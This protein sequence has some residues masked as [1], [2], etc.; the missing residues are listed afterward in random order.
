MPNRPATPPLIATLRAEHVHLAQISTLMTEQLDAIDSGTAVDSHILY[1]IMSYMVSWADRY[2]HPRE[3]LIYGRAAELDAQLADDVDSLQRQH[4]A[5]ASN[6]LAL[7]KLIGRWRAGKAT[8]AAVVRAGRDYV[9]NSDR[10]MQSEEQLVFPR[11]EAVLGP[12]DWQEL[13]LDD[14]LQAAGDPVFGP[15]IDREFRNLARKLRRSARRTIERGVMAE[16][17][18]LESALESLEILG[19]ANRMALQTTGDTLRCA[20]LE[21][22]DIVRDT[23]LTAAPRCAMN[24]AR[25]SGRWLGALATIAGDTVDDLARIRREM[26][27]QLDTLDTL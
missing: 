24:N 9:A 17:A 3:D 4:D 13:E 18:G 19:N 14:R 1:E 5:M 10:H 15:R 26:R 11:I 23:P 22:L 6:A 25:L 8:D 27:R 2:H 16:W 12:A 21:S 20:L 7:Q